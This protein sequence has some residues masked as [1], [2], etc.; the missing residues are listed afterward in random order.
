M[1]EF[2]IENE[3]PTTFLYDCH[4]FQYMVE[5]F[6]NFLVVPQK[7]HTNQE[8]MFFGVRINKETLLGKVFY[9]KRA[10]LHIT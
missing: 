10:P 5:P 4:N 2:A 3:A 7:S 6:S 1:T 8:A 9:P